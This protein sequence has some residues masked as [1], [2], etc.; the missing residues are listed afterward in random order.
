MAEATTPPVTAGAGRGRALGHWPVLVGLAACALITLDLVAGV[1]LAKVL[2]G[3]AV[4]YLG[5]AAAGSRRAAWPVF[6]LTVLVIVGCDIVAPDFEAAWAVLGLAVLLAGYGLAGRARH[7]APPRR[8]VTVQGVAM[9]AFAA[10]AV[11]ALY[12]SVTA[13]SIL[14]ALGLLAHAGWDVHHYRARTVVATSLAEFCLI[15]DTGLA[16]VIIAQV[17]M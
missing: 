6:A 7:H 13:G 11:T 5:A 14:V 12:V 8:P 16:V 4:V 10:I 2:A 9:L 1:E 3:S 17:V 15:L